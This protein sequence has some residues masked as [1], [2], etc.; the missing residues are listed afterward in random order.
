MKKLVFLLAFVLLLPSVFGA[1]MSSETNKDTISVFDMPTLPS[2]TPIEISRPVQFYESATGVSR[3]LQITNDSNNLR[4]NIEKGTIIKDVYGN[5]LTPL[6]SPPRK[7]LFNTIGI[8]FPDEKTVYEFLIT[9]GNNC[10][11]KKTN[12]VDLVFNKSKINA[13][14]EEEEECDSPPEYFYPPLK[15]TI[16]LPNNVEVDNFELRFYD[17]EKKE[18]SVQE[19]NYDH[20][21]NLITL[22]YPQTGYIAFVNDDGEIYTDEEK[23]EAEAYLKNK[24]IIS[25]DEKLFRDIYNSHWVRDDL[26]FMIERGVFELD[27]SRKFN[28]N[29]L[30]NR[31]EASKILTKTFNLPLS[32]DVDLID[33]SRSEWF[34][35]Y[36][37]T[38]I[39][40]GIMSAYKPRSFL[41]SKNISRAEAL[42][43]IL[44]AGKIKLDEAYRITPF[45]D[46]KNTDWFASAVAFAVDSE[47]ISR[48]DFFN[49]NA[50]V[51]RAEFVKM[52]KRVLVFSEN[53]D[54]K[55]L[56]DDFAGRRKEKEER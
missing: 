10:V 30:I 23:E 44:R 11:E 21:A 26:A 5:I 54:Q 24:I 14:K 46:V 48:K 42:T 32:E 50:T 4:I 12:D 8:Q 53:T 22:D 47:I 28:P 2:N 33:F 43:I 17:I 37:Q 13:L 27:T 56:L 18:W 1:E 52:A 15:F 34:S 25:K 41:P 16:P 31:A 45:L 19:F 39:D 29:A 20:I 6:L 9:F 40:L 36:A 7:T 49:P 51:S 35:K 55:N 3:P 38:M